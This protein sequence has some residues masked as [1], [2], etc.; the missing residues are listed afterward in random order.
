MLSK[1]GVSPLIATVLLIS[2]AVALGAVVMNWAG[3]IGVSDACND[4]EISVVTLNNEQQACYAPALE[5]VKVGISNGE[6]PII[7]VQMNVYSAKGN[8]QAQVLQTLDPEA[9][10]E[11]AMVYSVKELGVP[12]QVIIKPVVGQASDPEVCDVSVTVDNP[13]QC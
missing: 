9:R 2:F 11:Y 5:Q 7:G 12:Q 1:K 10:R 8:A 13:S 6:A 3:Q 4:V